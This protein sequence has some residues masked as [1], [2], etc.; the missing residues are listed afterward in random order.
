MIIDDDEDDQEIF[1]M[2]VKKISDHIECL[3][4]DNGVDAISMLDSNEGYIPDYI[5]IDMNMPKMN[6]IQCLKNI[7]TIER[8]K[9][10]QIFMYSTTFETTI[11]K[12]SKELGATDFMIKP[13]RTADLKEKL[14][15]IFSIV[16]VINPR[17]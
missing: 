12:E 8:L 10:S 5:F 14:S 7:K 11:V 9:N 2:C 16:S 3:I 4:A 15:N 17:Q 1:L 13:A 6:G